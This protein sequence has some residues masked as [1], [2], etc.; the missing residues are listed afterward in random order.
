MHWIQ[1]IRQG[2]NEKRFQ[3]YYQNI[4]P[5]GSNPEHDTHYEILL[6]M[7]ADDGRMIR[8]TEFIAAAERYHLMPAIDRWVV[9]HALELLSKRLLH[10]DLNSMFAINISGQSLDDEEFLDF[11]LNKLHH[12]TVSPEMICFE[13]TETVAATNLMVVQRFISVLRGIGCR[14][15]LDDF[16]RGISSFAYLKNL[17][18]DYLK[19]DGMFVKI[20]SLIKWFC[21]GGIHQSHRPYYGHTN[22]C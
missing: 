11:V 5:L 7:E 14:F 13:I 18:V 1:H 2:L 8:P 20:L 12:S 6:R 22:D 17:K 21:Y 4:V 10:S 16:G 15:S 9:T 3:L 19:I